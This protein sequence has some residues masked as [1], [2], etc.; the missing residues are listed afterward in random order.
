MADPVVFSRRVGFDPDPWQA[1]VLRSE[2]PR[3]L[4]CCSRQSGKST[5]VATRVL[6]EA[7]YK[8]DSMI[9][10][11]CPALRQSQEMFRKIMRCY[12]ALQ[13]IA[14][15]DALTKL[16]MELD[17]GSRIVALPGSEETIRSF[18]GVTLLV[19]DEASRIADEL[20][21][22]VSPMLAT[23]NGRVFAPSTPWGRRGW[24]FDAWSK[25]PGGMWAKV[26]ADWTQCPRITPA[27]VEGERAM[28]GS[29]WV[30]QEYECRFLETERTVLRESDI[31]AAFEEEVEQWQ[32]LPSLTR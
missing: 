32:L 29:N 1:Q 16:T 30:E 31:T 10:I 3:T 20:Y 7:L 9:L 23:S 13:R 27:F 2:H 28:F 18:S 14:P 8:P 15:A 21:A 24:F 4:L 12:R 22:S 5:T 17:N 6:W 25:N 19:L 26:A 11:V